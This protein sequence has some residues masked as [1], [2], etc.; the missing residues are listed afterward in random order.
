MKFKLFKIFKIF[1]IFTINECQQCIYFK[2]GKCTYSES[3]LP[4]DCL[5]D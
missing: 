2:K 4:G 1:K 3:G 5:Y